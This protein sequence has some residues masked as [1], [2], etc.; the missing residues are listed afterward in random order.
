MHLSFNTVH[1]KTAIGG[2][3]ILHKFCGTLQGVS[4]GEGSDGEGSE[5]DGSERDGSEGEG[6]GSSSFRE[7]TCIEAK[8][9]QTS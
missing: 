1:S 8:G 3:S 6:L 9:K 5:R 7:P 2:H 4:D